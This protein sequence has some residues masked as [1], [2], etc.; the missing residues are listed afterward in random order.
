[1]IKKELEVLDELKRR[2]D[3]ILTSVDKDAAIVIQDVQQNIKEAGRQL[4]NIRNYRQLPND[5]TKMNND[6]VN[7]TFK[8]FENEHLI[9]DKV[10]ERLI[11]E[12][13]TIQSLKFAKNESLGHQLLV[14]LI[15]TFQKY[16][17]IYI[18]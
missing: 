1:M 13:V 4:N 2:D 3:I 17:N 14:Q 15:A 6:T 9:K 16:W 18:D 5:P 12:N 11:I 7:K 10:A 8:R